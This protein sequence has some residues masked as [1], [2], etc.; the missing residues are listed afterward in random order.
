MWSA[1]SLLYTITIIIKV[2]LSIS[3]ECIDEPIFHQLN[4]C[5]QIFIIILKKN[6]LPESVSPMLIKNFKKFHTFFEPLK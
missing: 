6:V 2:S 1:P 4:K 5:F 3:N